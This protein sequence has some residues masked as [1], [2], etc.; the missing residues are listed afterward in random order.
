MLRW[1]CADDL[2]TGAAHVAPNGGCVLM[3]H[4]VHDAPFAVR[5]IKPLGCR[6]LLKIDGVLTPAMFKV[7]Q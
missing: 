2:G 3:R 5:P 1:I 6:R 7:P 4:V